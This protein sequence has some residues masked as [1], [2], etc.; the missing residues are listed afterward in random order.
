MFYK[1]RIMDIKDGLPKWEGMKE[2]SELV[3]E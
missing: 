2:D 1:D 3:E